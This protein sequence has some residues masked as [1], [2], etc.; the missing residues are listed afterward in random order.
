MGCPAELAFFR[1]MSVHILASYICPTF[2]AT[3]CRT[4]VRVGDPGGGTKGCAL[5]G[6][7]LGGFI[8]VGRLRHCRSRRG[9][10]YRSH[11]AGAGCELCIHGAILCF[12]WEVVRVV[13]SSRVLLTNDFKS[14]N[15]Q[16]RAGRCSRPYYCA[17][18]NETATGRD[19]EADFG[20]TVT[21]YTNGCCRRRIPSERR[22]SDR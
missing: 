7:R 18:G 14:A 22:Q 10:S 17:Q 11:Q 12:G 13:V 4:T 8:G 3:H 15:C 16:L 9:R 2:R 19:V 5:R 6:L 1:T 21:T 20:A